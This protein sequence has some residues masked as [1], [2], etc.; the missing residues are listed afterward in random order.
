MKVRSFT[1]HPVYP[2]T[3]SKRHEIDFMQTT[4]ASQHRPL[5]PILTCIF[6]L[7]LA[8]LTAA[9][10]MHHKA[11]ETKTR[12]STQLQQA[13]AFIDAFYSFDSAQLGPLMNEAPESKAQLLYYQGWAEGGNYVVLNR[14]PC[15]FEE[16]D[17]IAC[18][19]TVR[20]DPVVALNTGFNV[21]DTFHL[22]FKGE[23]LV[24]VDTSSNDQP[25]YYEA[26][27][28]VEANQPEVMSGPCKGR[29]TPQATPGKCARAM[30]KGYQAFYETVVLPGKK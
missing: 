14:E 11:G 5:Y 10:A 8:P 3:T 27:K 4:L 1:K 21:T 24:A 26:R 25:I 17:N 19:V 7:G 12:P 15:V 28:W 29:G 20:D 18:P 6:L 9:F 30:T 16:P 22:T 13:E 2:S 23:T